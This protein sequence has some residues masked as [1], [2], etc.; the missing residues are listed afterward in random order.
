MRCTIGVDAALGLVHSGVST[1]ANGHELNTAAERLHGEEKV[2]YGDS[3]HLG[4]EKREAFQG[5]ACQFRIGMRPGQRRA[6][7]NTPEGRLE[8]L[9]ETAKAH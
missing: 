7:P 4:I 9:I 5:S 6:L 3:G 2:D 8:D 1:A